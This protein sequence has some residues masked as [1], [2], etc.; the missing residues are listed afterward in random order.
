L[1][2]DTDALRRISY[3]LRDYAATAGLQ[4]RLRLVGAASMSAAKVVR[5]LCKV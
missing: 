1:T 2:L 4:T 3:S 5:K